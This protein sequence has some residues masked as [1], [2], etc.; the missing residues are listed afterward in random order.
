MSKGSHRDQYFTNLLIGFAFLIGCMLVIYYSIFELKR[1]TD[2]YYIALLAAVLL[3][4][5]I[6]FTLSAFV[7][8]VKADFSK[9]QKAKEM[10]RSP[11]SED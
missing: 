10:Q 5:G 9:R 2:W 11:G 4:A 1:E 3:C 8:K 6:Y 7:H